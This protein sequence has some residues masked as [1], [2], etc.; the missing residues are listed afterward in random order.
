MQ[1]QKKILFLGGAPSQVPII[2][3][4]KSRGFYIITC[5]YLP[6]NPGHKLADE[7]Y[8]ISTTDVQSVLKLAEELGPDFIVAYASD[9]AAPV[10]SYVSEKLNKPGNSYQSTRTLAEKDLFRDFLKHNSFNVPNFISTD[11][12]SYKNL[13]DKFN[14][15]FPVIV[16]P[17]DSSGSKGVSLVDSIDNLTGAVDY[18]MKFSRSGKV[19]IEEY[20]DNSQGDLHG[21]GFVLNG[22]LIFSCLGD[23]IYNKLSN[24]FNPCG[25]LWPSKVSSDLIKK[26]EAEVNKII[27]KSGFSFGP[28]NIEARINSEGKLFIMEIGPRNGGHYVPQAIKYSTGFD[29]VKF[30][31]DVLENKN[32]EIKNFD[33]NNYKFVS[34]FAIHTDHKGIFKDLNISDEIKPFIKE[35]FLYMSPGTEVNSFISSNSAVGV[36]ILQFSSRFEM[37]YF[38]NNFQKLISV[39]LIN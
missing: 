32:I 24:P 33:Y 37:E 7:Y 8:N 36:V 21:D 11:K 28:I 6:N 15:Q 16:K 12:H 10:A 34:Y 23:H 26:V 25:T 4:A 19:I 22:K 18:S 3:E 9:P 20:I 39:N 2:V 27:N 31:L 17:N 1:K 14:L 30:Y 35:I 38:S 13:I 5:D 29:L